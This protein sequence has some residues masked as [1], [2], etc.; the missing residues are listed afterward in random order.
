MSK[1]ALTDEE[2]YSVTLAY[3]FSYFCKLHET[4]EDDNCGFCHIDPNI[5]KVLFENEHWI[6]F[7]N[8]FKN[9]RPCEVM[10][11]IISREHWRKLGDI[12]PRAWASFAEMI[13]FAEE[14]YNLPGGM[15]FL[16]FGDMRLNA[17]TMPHLHWNIWVPNGSGTLNI[18]LYKSVE[19]RAKDVARGLE[20]QK[21]YDAG[22]RA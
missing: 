11:V 12:T 22:E 6:I 15:L 18:P 20:F 8:A 14:N 4:F 3:E 10:L 7:E 21:R 17:G 19:E 1:R 5:N 2:K 9:V 13:S 16:R